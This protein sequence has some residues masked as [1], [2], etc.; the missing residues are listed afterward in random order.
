M[1]GDH[2][3]KSWSATQSTVALSSGE[4][5]LSGLV[6]GIAQAIGLQSVAGDLG[7]QRTIHVLS[8]ATAAIG[9]CRRRG[10]GKVRHL[11]VADL[12]IQD[13][14]KC[15]EVSLSKVLGLDNPADLLTKY[16]DGPAQDKHI[17]RIGLMS[18]TGRAESAPKLPKGDGGA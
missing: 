9:M 12:W 7:D 6:K 4:A 17:Q 14:V 5:E 8:D 15:G 11:A 1:I 13:K 16:L 2:L 10:L 18:E 3:I